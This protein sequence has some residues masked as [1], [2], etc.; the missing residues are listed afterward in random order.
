[1][2]PTSIKLICAFIY[3][4]FCDI[5]Y[6]QAIQEYK[7][8]DSIIAKSYK[9]ITD[10]CFSSKAN[11]PER[12]LYT[13]ALLKKAKKESNALEK[14]KAYR[15]ISFNH[16]DNLPVRI[17]YLDS[18]IVF[19]K[20]L[21]HQ[22]YPVVSYLNLGGLYLNNSN[23]TEALNNYLKALEYSKKKEDKYYYYVT[24]HN[25]GLLKLKIGEHKEAAKIFKEVIE[26]EN[27]KTKSI[28]LKER[29]KSFILLANSLRKLKLNDSATYYNQKGIKLSIKDTSNIYYHLVLNEGINLYDQQ[30][31][32]QA[33]DSIQKATPYV[34]I[35][36]LLNGE[37]IVN[38]YLYEGK[39][40]HKRGDNKRFL[41]VLEKLDNYLEKK[42]FTSMESRDCYEMLINYYK[43]KNDKNKQ[44]LYTNKLIKYDS[45]IYQN[46]RSLSTR[47]VKEY[48][49][50][51][52][53]KEKKQ[54]ITEISNRSK[55]HTYIFSGV[56]T[57]T[58]IILII[59]LF[60]YSK[61]RTYKKRYNQ[62]LINISNK[63]NKEHNKETSKIKEIGISED[64]VDTVLS[65]LKNFES[66][67]AYLHNDLTLTKL[68]QEFKTNSK[69]ISKIINYHKEKSFVNYVNELRI[70]YITEKIKNDPKFRNYT[71]LALAREV[72]FKTSESF[73]KAFYKINGISPSY[74][75]KEL[76][77]TTEFDK[78]LLEN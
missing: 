69:Y 11:T 4:I 6:S 53:L 50:P 43:R 3:I 20:E 23:Y 21:N 8:S 44:L 56:I 26:Y 68:S 74:F 41:N 22:K 73:T 77:S 2:K 70:H 27:S 47:I 55:T 25:I 10:L 51:L 39:I 1:M 31:Y 32:A 65:Q 46:Y 16:Y 67:K 40:Y 33:L 38:A 49:T 60:N 75:I 48:D 63:D 72:G 62:L 28:E 7:I 59:L 58:S 24:I 37:F 35:D 71:L 45:L 30:K 34:E 78:K 5:I 12:I 19:S 42:K 54:L 18:S 13:N 52:L 36:S 29:L 57:I 64:I 9:E 66:N 15:F 14:A 17:A 61:N 76:G